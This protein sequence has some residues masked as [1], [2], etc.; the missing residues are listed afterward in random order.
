MCGS[1]LVPGFGSSLLYYIVVYTGPVG[2]AFEPR[3]AEM[4]SI[5]IL[6]RYS[7]ASYTVDLPQSGPT[8][9]WVVV[10]CQLA[11]ISFAWGGRQKMPAGIFCML[12]TV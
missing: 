8:S 1:L 12:S 7:L 10:V 2:I 11:F 3:S 4:Y 6:Y 5:E 9:T